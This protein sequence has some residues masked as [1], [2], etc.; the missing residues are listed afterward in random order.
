MSSEPSASNE[1]GD[2]SARP[3]LVPSTDGP[4]MGDQAT[5]WSF[6]RLRGT[7]HRNRIVLPI[8]ITLLV[9]S[10][11]GASV[12]A[13][14][15]PVAVIAVVFVLLLGNAWWRVERQ[16]GRHLSRIGRMLAEHPWRP[17][18][19]RLVRTGER[20]MPV[21]A[22]SD[23]AGTRLSLVGAPLGTQHVLA[24][25]G[26]VWLIGPESG[27]A[28]LRVDGLTGLILGHVVTDVQEGQA[29]EP[30]LPRAPYTGSAADDV[31][32]SWVASKAMRAARRSLIVSNFVRVLVFLLVFMILVVEFGSDGIPIDA[33]VGVV[34]LVLCV[35]LAFFERR[36]VGNTMRLPALLRAGPWQRVPARFEPWSP[37]RNPAGVA[38]ARGELDGVAVRIPRASINLMTYARETGT[39]WIAGRPEPGRSVAVGIAGHPI[40]AV[41][42]FPA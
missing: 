10:A 6:Q 17:V 2:L 36:R 25:Q 9:L 24:R 29:S 34:L 1:P 31:V 42:T 33:V 15:L 27:V 7:V 22:L 41:A 26:R 4:A 30:L 14:G 12:G 37:G 20:P 11:V 28:V 40:L 23:S 39:L 21:I 35:L 19:A 13:V 38:P 18:P 8:M 16:V 5:G 3:V 32:A